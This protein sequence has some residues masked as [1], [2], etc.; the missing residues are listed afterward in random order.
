[1]VSF[2]D[3]LVAPM[4]LLNALIVAVSSRNRCRVEQ[5]F[6][7]LETLWDRNDVY[8]KDVLYPYNRRRRCRYVLRRPRR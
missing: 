6:R 1:M 4:S 3:S 7:K 8:K 2:V 5:T